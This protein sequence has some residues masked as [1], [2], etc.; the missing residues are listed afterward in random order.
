MMSYRSR[1]TMS[2]CSDGEKGGTDENA[3]GEYISNKRQSKSI[4]KSS[5]RKGGLIKEVTTGVEEWVR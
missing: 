4:L 2:E 5:R 1:L 3:Q